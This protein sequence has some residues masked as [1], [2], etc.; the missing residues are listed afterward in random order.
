[1]SEVKLY[2]IDKWQQLLQEIKSLYFNSFPIEERR[3]WFDIERLLQTDLSGYNMKVIMHHNQ[4]AGFISWWRFDRFCYIEHFA[5]NPNARGNGIGSQALKLFIDEVRLAVVLEVELPH[6]GEMARRRIDFYCRNGFVAHPH[7]NYTQ[8]PYSKE[9]PSVPL[10]LM[11]ANAPA[12]IDLNH[13]TSTL[14]K[15]VYNI[16]A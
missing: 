2:N 5:I 11:T 12:N 8:P 15:E 9:L 13:I 1:M 10:M 14:H 3:E 7:F 16:K 4:F 6:E